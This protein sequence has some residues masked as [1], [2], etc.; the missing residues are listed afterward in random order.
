MRGPGRGEQ[1]EFEEALQRYT[2]GEDCPVFAGLY[3]YCAKYAGGSV[4]GAVRLNWGQ[5]DIAVNWAG[6]LNHG[7]KSEVTRAA[8]RLATPLSSPSHACA[9]FGRSFVRSKQGARSTLARKGGW[10]GGGQTFIVKQRRPCS[11]QGEVGLSR[12]GG[13]AS[14]ILGGRCV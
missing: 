6:G 10:G 14:S 8:P 7:K 2:V 12:I 1:D 13:G 9:M 3:D 4:G 11:A 5:A